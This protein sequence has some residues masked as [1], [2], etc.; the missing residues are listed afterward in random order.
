MSRYFLFFTVLLSILLTGCGEQSSQPLEITP[1][2]CSLRPGE[3]ITFS[4]KGV[5]GSNPTIS[6]NATNG[7]IQAQDKAGLLAVFTAP[8]TPGVVEITVNVSNNLTPMSPLSISC[9]ILPDTPLAPGS[10]LPPQLPAQSQPI[11]SFVGAPTVIVSEVMGH[12]CGADDFKKFNQYVELYNYGDQ[13]VDVNGWWLVDNGPGNQP[14]QLVAWSTRNPRAS[15][16]QNV[17]TNST[18]IP[19]HGFAVVISPIY[20]EGIKPYKMPYRFSN[21]TVI[22][23]VAESDRIGDDLYGLVE[24]QNGGD[25]VVLYLGGPNTIKQIISTYGSPT[26]GLYPQDVRDDHEDNLPLSLHECASAERINP[27][28][29]D[30][31]GNW[32]EVLNGSPG[33]APYP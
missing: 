13:P 8:Q 31:F 1:S 29:P 19:P 32:R 11:N 26:L 33:E 28:G 24:D 22:L 23:T 7:I 9:L 16:K 20:T 10:Q 30:E 2:K 6:W 12:Q 25:V 21:Q 5:I 18:L 17:V 3:Q 27:T 14:D 4:M 15:L